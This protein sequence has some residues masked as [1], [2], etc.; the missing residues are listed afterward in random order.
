M[1][2]VNEETAIFQRKTLGFWVYLMTDCVLF[3]TLLQRLRYYA[4]QLPAGH[5]VPTSSISILF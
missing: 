2:Q 4:R 5:L 1:K 3:A